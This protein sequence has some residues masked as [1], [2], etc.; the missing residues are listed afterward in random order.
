MLRTLSIIKSWFESGDKPTQEQFSDTWDSFWHK[1]EIIP[2]SNI[3]DLNNRFEEK[4]DAQAFISHVNDP[5]AHGL[6][7]I[8]T[9]FKTMVAV[10]AD[11][12]INW[13]T[14]VIP[15]DVLTYA[16]K[17]GNHIAS[18]EGSYVDGGVIR[19]YKPNYNYTLVNGVIQV[20][21]ITE[22]FPGT[23]TII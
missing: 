7:N 11:K 20:L 4:A 23:I 6:G 14:D 22:V 19:G 10:E 1:S 2:T 5:T 12:A 13:Q 16:Q 8:M 15:G 18:L 3:E 9:K 21:N 17:H